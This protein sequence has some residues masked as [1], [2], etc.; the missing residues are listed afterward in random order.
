M[1]VRFGT[2]S[3]AVAATLLLAGLAEPA[4]A[5]GVP[6]FPGSRAAR[7]APLQAPV[8]AVAA[9]APAGG[10]DA[11]LSL[12]L[13]QASIGTALRLISEVSQANIVATQ[14]A[15][16]RELSLY[17]NRATARAALDAVTRAAGLWVRWRP[18]SQSY[19]VMTSD[20]YQ[21]DLTVFGEE[22]SE[23]FALRHHNVVAAAHAL[24]ALFGSRVRLQAPQ[25]EPLGESMKHTDLR[26]N[27][28]PTAATA[29]NTRNASTSPAGAN[30]TDAQ[31]VQRTQLGG[32]RGGGD[33]GQVAAAG[34]A[35]GASQ[36]QVEAAQQGQE[37]PIFLT[38]NRLHN[39]LVLRTGD[40]RAMG[41]ARDLLRRLDLPARQVM[42]EMRIIQVRMDDEFRRA[43]DMDFFSNSA[44]TGT[45]ITST[46]QAVNPLT[47]ASTGPRTVGSLGD[48]SAFDKA[49]GLLQFISNRIRV[50]LQLLEENGRVQT[51]AKPL[52][53][54]SNNEP[55]RL[56]IG[57]EVVLTTGASAQTTTGTTGA[58]NT[59]IT[60]ETEKRNIG[61]TLV[62]H[63]RIND[64]RTVTLTIDQESSERVAGGTT[65]PLA[66]GTAGDG[67][68]QYPIDTVNTATVQAVAQ[69]KDGLTIAV[70][71]L[72]KISKSKTEGNVPGFSRIPLLGELFKSDQR[73]DERSELM[74]IITPHVLESAEDGQRLSNQLG[75]HA[76]K[77]QSL[78][79]K[80]EV[81][82]QASDPTPFAQ[83]MAELALAGL[84]EAQP[85]WESDPAVKRLSAEDLEGLAPQAAGLGR[86]RVLGA[87]QWGRLHAVA[88]ELADGQAAALAAPQ[89]SV[90][91]GRWLALALE[92]TTR[93]STGG[94]ATFTRRAVWVTDEAWPEVARRWR[95]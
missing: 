34:A 29:V 79:L 9:P 3:L 39:L 28:G 81:P 52:L 86:A 30:G 82:A 44:A 33:T 17:L 38:Y 15:A 11:S 50:R 36:S 31:G 1:G 2:R 95:P 89:S 22:R 25:E 18:S 6:A 35:V 41:Q 5:D 10:M 66:T 73:V 24:R 7:P 54:A 37:A 91:P 40:D 13:R 80:T 21:R 74:L 46:N 70:G 75:G 57:E 49:T 92:P 83:T 64:D 48:T 56:F 62:I 8:G 60:A 16:D 65:I 4:W 51:L 67:V 72:I 87:W 43:L 32:L 23:V 93:V 61:T 12:D 94:P 84:D 58:T 19:L 53:L 27:S 59:V 26:R 63:P 71:G 69:A 20:E 14:A 76:L 55:A 68:I 45:A 90:L 78:G 47:G 42:L 88:V 85:M 77:A